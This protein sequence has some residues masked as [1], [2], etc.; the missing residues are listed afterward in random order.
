MTFRVGGVLLS[1]AVLAGG[2]KFDEGYFNRRIEE[3]DQIAA[4]A[5]PE[6][7]KKIEQKKTE[8]RQAFDR[9]PA[10]GRSAALHELGKRAKAAVGEAEKLLAGEAEAAKRVEAAKLQEYRKLFVGTWKGKGMHL[11]IS[12][13]GSVHYER[14]QGGAMSRKVT[15]PITEF[16]RGHF[17]VGFM[18]ITTTFRID[19]PPREVDGVWKM[20]VDGVEL[21]RVEESAGKPKLGA[22]LCTKLEGGQ[23]ADPKT[24][25]GLETE[26]LHLVYVTPKV[27]AKGQKYNVAWI[28]EDVGKAAP[29]N[30][31][32]ADTDLVYDGADQ[33]RATH[34][35]V[36]AHLSRPKA[37]WPPGA[38][39]VEVRFEGEVVSTV[40][41]R[42]GAAAAEQPR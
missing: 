22:A 36:T 1:L 2:C 18:G 15:A 3:L 33:E 16:Q 9:L 4:K 20:K 29:A 14:G 41:F 32:I 13:A 30:F 6:T 25:F 34:F 7:R 38:Y 11:A 31:K 40:K 35:T 23:C 8:L 24:A 27:P 10:E 17:K 28:A 39:R 19:Q 42:M 26:K 21:T 5:G 37:G 12:P